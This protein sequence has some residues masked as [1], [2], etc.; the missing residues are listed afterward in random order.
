LRK[1]ASVTMNYEFRTDEAFARKLDSEDPLA[2][3]PIERKAI[4]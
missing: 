1:E 3:F 4:S 2:K